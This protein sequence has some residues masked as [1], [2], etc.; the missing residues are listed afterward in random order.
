M[1]VETHGVI[2]PLQSLDLS[3]REALQRWTVRV[4]LRGGGLPPIFLLHFHIF[5]F[6]KMWH[7]QIQNTR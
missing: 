5:W 4:C 7:A 3:K 2:P 1:G 6:N